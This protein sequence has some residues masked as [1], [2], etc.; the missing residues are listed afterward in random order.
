VFGSHV[1][2]AAGL[3]EE[4]AHIACAHSLVGQ[5]IGVSSE[6]RIVGHADQADWSMAEMPRTASISST[7]RKHNGN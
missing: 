3:P 6:C 5:H 4:I 2:L 1:C 7:V